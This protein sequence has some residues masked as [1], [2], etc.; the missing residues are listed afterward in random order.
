ME[1]V[2]EFLFELLAEIVGEVLSAVIEFFIFKGKKPTQN[3]G[4]LNKG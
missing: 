4:M 1:S 2:F 3:K